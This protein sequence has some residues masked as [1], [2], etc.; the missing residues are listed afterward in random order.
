MCN[1]T[2]NELHNR[3]LD[4]CYFLIMCF[5]T[6]INIRKDDE[7]L[8]KEVYLFFAC[9]LQGVRKFIDIVYA[10]EFTKTSDWYN[11]L[12]TIKKRGTDVVLYANIPDNKHLKDALSLAFKDIKI[13]L[14]CYGAI[15]TIFK[16][17]TP[18]YSTNVFKIIRKIYLSETIDDYYDSI[19]LFKN[20]FSSSQFIIDI[21]EKDLDIVK[22]YYSTSLLLRK[23]IIS[24]YFYREIRKKLYS[25]SHSKAYFEN[26][27]EFL[28]LLIP[29]IYIIE[30][31]CY[32]PKK[33]WINVINEIYIPNKD[34]LKCYF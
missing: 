32:C 20:E 7:I 30:S 34:L 15:D 24:F 12:L 33:E 25:F 2:T 27:D 10:D 19:K 21:L 6:K 8:R 23:H 16:Y 26:S 5:K 4:G 1:L 22:S 17:Y 31:K 18:N 11:F 29:K 3:K 28:E 14:S 9:N 13:F